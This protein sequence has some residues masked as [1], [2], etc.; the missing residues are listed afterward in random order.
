MLEYFGK[1]GTVFLEVVSIFSP[2]E[3]KKNTAKGKEAFQGTFVVI[4]EGFA[5]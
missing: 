3:K 4:V 2:R 5:R 1:S